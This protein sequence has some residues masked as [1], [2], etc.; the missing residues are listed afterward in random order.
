MAQRIKIRRDTAANWS[1][2]NPILSLGEQG[3][4]T[5]TKQIKIGD[6]E[7]SWNNLPYYRGFF[8]SEKEEKLNGI[9]SNAQVNAIQSISINN[10]NVA[11]DAQKNVNID[12][13]KLDGIEKGAQVNKIE[14]IKVN[15]ITQSI[16]GKTVNLKIDNK[17]VKTILGVRRKITGNTSSA[18][19]RTDDAV[20]LVANA[21]KDGSSVQNDFDS[22]YPWSDIKSYMYNPTTK[23]RIADYGDPNFDFNTTQYEIMTYI[24]EFYYKRYV[25]NDY[26]YIKISSVAVD[27]FNKS[28]AFSIAR[29]ESS[30][31]GTKLHSRSGTYP[32]VNRNITSFR[33][34]SKEVGD[35]FGQ[36]DY[37][38]C[39]L[40]LLYLVE[41][42]NFNSQSILGK[43]ATYL[44]VSDSDKALIAE[45]GV[46]R[47]ILSTSNA[48]NFIVGQQVS[49]GTSSAWN[50]S[51]AKNRTITAIEDYSSGNIT[52]KAIYFDG[53]PVNIAVNNVLWTTGQKSGQLNSLGMKSGCLNNDGKHCIIYRGIENLFGN[54][55]KFVDGLNIKDY[56]AYICYEPDSYSVDT[57]TEPYK[58]LGY[59]NAKANGYSKNLGYDENHPLLAFPTEVGASDSTGT[60]DYYY[61]NSGN[62][63]ALVG[64]SYDCDG[65]AGAWYWDF[66]YTS[67]NTYY[68]LGSR[69]LLNQ[70]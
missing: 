39:I 1:Q 11:P 21:T 9:A 57:F 33:T 6:G 49:I 34:L 8:T 38:Y 46:N 52:G 27:G 22:I 15:G 50:W 23:E 14:T 48:N 7:T 69:L 3:Y 70:N 18:W 61:Q 44:R 60:C 53:D 56:I 29:Y 59:T 19:E 63:I 26:E 64:G 31:D 12:L 37:R 67:S 36:L 58:A 47:I 65:S 40:Q 32:E 55:W 68:H 4:E 35:G 17:S 24:P 5:D 25:E 66:H 10:V 62:R 28:P 13:T 30:Y 43:G 20:G 16:S 45:N 2:Y 51:V 54:I 42:A 41:Y